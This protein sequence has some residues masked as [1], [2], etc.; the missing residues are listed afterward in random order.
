MERSI[1]MMIRLEGNNMVNEFW[2]RQNSSELKDLL[3]REISLN[4]KVVRADS[5]WKGFIQVCQITKIKDGRM[6][7]DDSKVPI[8]FPGR[9][10]LVDI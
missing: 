6:F 9:C 7:L 5:F 8:Q 2:D 1:G 10:L 3:G 4:D